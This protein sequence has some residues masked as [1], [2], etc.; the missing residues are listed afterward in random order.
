LARNL[1]GRIRSGKVDYEKYRKAYENTFSAEGLGGRDVI[2]SSEYLFDLSARNVR[3]LREHLDRAGVTKYLVVAFVRHP[4][5]YYLSYVQQQLK[6]SHQVPD[7][8]RFRYRLRSV[9]SAWS[10]VFGNL[11]VRDFDELLESGGDVVA[12]FSDIVE[13]S[14]WGRLDL[15]PVRANPGL[16]AE[17]MVLLQRY[18]QAFHADSHNVFEP[19]SDRLLSVIA[20]LPRRGTRPRLRDDVRQLLSA[21]HEDDIV[22]LQRHFGLF[23]NYQADSG[24]HSRIDWEAEKP[25]KV[26]RLLH[27]L[28]EASVQDFSLAVLRQLLVE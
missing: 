1:K 4:A 22:Y 14:E 24:S 3:A 21:R 2:L 28:S 20:G 18:R 23:G 13:Q 8:R 10:E 17:A 12:T 11:V 5:S 19:D 7:P 16:C 26:E 27:G 15:Q 25:V 9:L 6:A